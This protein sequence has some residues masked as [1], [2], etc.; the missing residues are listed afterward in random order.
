MA[1]ISKWNGY[2]EGAARIRKSVVFG[3]TLPGVREC[4]LV[5]YHAGTDRVAET[6]HL[7]ESVRC[8]DAFSFCVEGI[9]GKKFD[10]VYRTEQGEIIDPCAASVTGRE[11]FGAGAPVT[12]G[13]FRQLSAQEPF[14]HGSQS[15]D[16]FLYRLH[17]RGFT[18]DP[19]SRISA[20][21]TFAG[22][23]KKARYLRELGV[24]AVELM[25]VYEF[26]ETSVLSHG[27]VRPMRPGQVNY[28]GYASPA[29][30]FAPKN[31]Y[32]QGESCEEFL[33]MVKTFHR[34]GIAV[35]LEFYFDET[36]SQERALHVLRHWKLCY[37]VDG[38]RV[39]GAHIGAAA[40]QR[41]PVL[42][43]CLIL[44]S[45]LDG[46]ADDGERRILYENDH[47]AYVLRRYLLGLSDGRRDLQDLWNYYHPT[48]RRVNY[49]ADCHGFTLWDV[50][51][52]NVKHNEAN[53]EDNFD[54]P[55]VNHSYNCGI[56]GPAGSR[57][58]EKLRMQMVKNILTLTFLANG[59]PMISAG[60]EMGHSA[61]GNNNPYNQDNEINWLN[62]RCGR[63]GEEIRAF[64]REL[65]S[66]RRAHPA[67]NAVGKLTE[68][69]VRLYGAPD[70][71]VHGSEPYLRGSGTQE[72]GFFYYGR[73][74]DDASIF[75]ACNMDPEERTI[76][77]P[78]LRTR[79]VWKV[80]IQT[81]EQPVT[82]PEEGPLTLPGR[83]IAVL[84]REEVPEGK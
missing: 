41:D 46:C 21:G 39:G 29:Y 19:T 68:R 15:E 69:D 5:I 7:D 14:L 72:C 13:G 6:L 51:S 43:D 9:S 59:V 70:Y 62:W 54:G 47:F 27:R 58:V 55:S 52:Y 57:K 1:K 16:L 42:A 79:G 10:Y 25:P 64:I 4:D 32:A 49:A 24:N 45:D 8:G 26:D 35:I 28:W 2:L 23:A 37:G 20:R 18:M 60:D 38:F 82:V 74:F 50:Y 66:F 78:E 81:A 76:Y 65:A 34:E 40:A 61:L 67:V 83:S 71:S 12:R 22:A 33:Q 84:L 44:G 30:Y 77:L 80:E 11:T 17:V 31:S 56:E 53:G 3:I 63:R 75:I 73:Y 48:F 36:V